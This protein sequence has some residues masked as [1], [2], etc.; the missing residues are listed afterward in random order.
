MSISP[1]SGNIYVNQGAS[2]VSNVQGDNQA[3][4]DFANAIAGEAAKAEKNE[5]LEV[6]PAEEIY[7]IDPE[8]EHEKNKR[9]QQNKKSRSKR[10]NSGDK[11]EE[12]QIQGSNLDIEI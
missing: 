1:V 8:K 7:K 4:G 3:R 10:E 9:E 6:R 5:L 11:G 2:V 12:N